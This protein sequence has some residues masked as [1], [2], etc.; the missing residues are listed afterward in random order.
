MRLL[1]LGDLF[2]QPGRDFLAQQMPRLRQ[3]YG[4]DLVVVNGENSASGSGI[5][6]KI[7]ESL[8]RAG[9]DVVTLG[10]HALRR[11]EIFPTLELATEEI[12]IIRPA[13]FPP[14]APGRGMTVVRTASGVRIAVLNLQG[15]TFMNPVDCPLAAADRLLATLPSDVVVRLVD[16]HAEATSDK[17]VMGRY[18]DGRVSAVIGTHT[19]VQTAD[20][21]IFP[22]GTAFLTD[23]GMCGPYE[24]IIGSQI[25]QVIPVMR[26]GCPMR[27]EVAKQD[28]R[29]SGAI[30]EVDAET[31]HAQHIERFHLR[32]DTLVAK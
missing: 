19:H 6:P 10:D 14:E 16:Y 18:L 26:T 29:L 2:G 30:I 24:S 11:S 9:V 31:G 22:N 23:A 25:K 5:S 17:Q 32:Q 15:R 3:E 4:L 13:N 8:L 27:F 1:F 28:V 7:F 21:R 20:E 12:R